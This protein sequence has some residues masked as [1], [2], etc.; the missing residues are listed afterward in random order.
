MKFPSRCRA[1]RSTRCRAANIGAGRAAAARGFTLFEVLIAFIIAAIAL[2]ALFDGSLAGLMSGQAATG[3]EQA[4]ARARSH[5]AAETASPAPG[6]REGDDGGGFRWRVRV[7]PVE[8]YQPKPAE[9]EGA[10]A[11]VASPAFAVTLYAVDVVISWSAGGRE[12][13]VQLQTERLAPSL[14]GVR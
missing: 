5:L 2:S 13:S 6:D 3:Y 12:R 10:L 11:Q 14:V 1:G 8:T 4:V 9:N 7:R